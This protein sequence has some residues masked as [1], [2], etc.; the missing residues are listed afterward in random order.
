MTYADEYDILKKA[1]RTLS[2]QIRQLE[3]D[4]EMCRADWAQCIAELRLIIAL[5][6]STIKLLS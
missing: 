5:L 1:R 3:H 6:E 2:K 4:G